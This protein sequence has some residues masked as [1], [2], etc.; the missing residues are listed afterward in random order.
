MT[1]AQALGN[2]A[3]GGHKPVKVV[4]REKVNN[5]AKYVVK[6]RE[7]GEVVAEFEDE[8]EAQNE[9]RWQEAGDVVQGRFKDDQYEIV[10]VEMR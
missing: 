1:R 9:I 2:V 7:T 4:E 6:I 8:H 5:M 10:K 3:N